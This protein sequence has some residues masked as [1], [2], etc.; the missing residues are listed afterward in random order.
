LLCAGI[1]DGEGFGQLLVEVR[2]IAVMKRT[3]F[4]KD[5]NQQ[6]CFLPERLFGVSPAQQPKSNL[7]FGS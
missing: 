3:G 2:A 1:K 5:A 6:H 4:R 7:L